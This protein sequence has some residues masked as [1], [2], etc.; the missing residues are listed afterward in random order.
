MWA[1]TGIEDQISAYAPTGLGDGLLGVEVDLLVVD[2]PPEPFDE[3]IVAPR[4]FNAIE[5][6]ISG[7]FITAVKSMERELRSLIGVDFGGLP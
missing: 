6:M 5:I 1:S 7:F 4:V 3:D 2:R